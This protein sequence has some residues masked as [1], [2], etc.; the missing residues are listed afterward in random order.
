VD[1]LNYPRAKIIKKARSID[2]LL[3]E[4]YG[5]KLSRKKTDPTSE[6]ILTILSQNTNDRNRDKAYAELRR[7]FPTWRDVAGARQQEI[8]RAIKIGGLS[9]IKSERIK[10]ILKEIAAKSADYDLSFLQGLPDNEVWDYLMS[11]KGVGPKTAAC[12]MIFALGRKTMP[13]DT[14]VHRVGRR[15]GLI[16]PQMSPEQAHKWFLDLNL[17]LNI[18]QLHINMI[19][20]GRALCRP[21]SP[22]CP[23]CNLKRNCLFYRERIIG[24]GGR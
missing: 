21:R 5:L 7:K 22:K 15:L 8:A 1:K 23:E 14:H 12:V 20:H 16:P 17:P 6:L 19:W 2:K 10:K 3:V 13:V 24:E 11:F 4:V 9:K 18:Y